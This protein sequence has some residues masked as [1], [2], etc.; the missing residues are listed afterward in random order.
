M[1]GTLSKLGVRRPK[2]PTPNSTHV[3]CRPAIRQKCKT[4]ERRRKKSANT[5]LW[6]AF[7]NDTY[8]APFPVDD[9]VNHIRHFSLRYPKPAAI[10]EA[11]DGLP[12]NGYGLSA[13]RRSI[14][15][16]AGRGH[17]KAIPL[18]ILFG[19]AVDAAGLVWLRPAE[20]AH[21]DPATFAI[22]SLNVASERN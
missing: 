17:I 8:F 2:L 16:F 10:A 19:R 5:W 3:R 11:L 18:A 7:V 15:I 1:S 14:V 4:G 20:P 13:V 12:P 6:Q 9:L 21:F 22:T